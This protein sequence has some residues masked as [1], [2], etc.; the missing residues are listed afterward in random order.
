MEE[1]EKEEKE[2]NQTVEKSAKEAKKEKRQWV[3]TMEQGLD[4]MKNDPVA[5]AT[6]VELRR[7]G[8]DEK[9]IA[10]C[11]RREGYTKLTLQN[12]WASTSPMDVVL[13]LWLAGFRP[14]DAEVQ[15][16]FADVAD[17]AHATVSLPKSEAGAA[18]EWADRRWWRGLEL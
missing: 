18:Q 16:L 5:R 1:S 2:A 17:L 15:M 10:G 4:C 9:K 7:N 6:L 11:G 8:F 14:V 3:T 12:V 13:L